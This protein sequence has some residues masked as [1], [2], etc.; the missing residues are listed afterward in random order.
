MDI[1]DDVSITDSG[2]DLAGAININ[3]AQLE[4]LAALPGFDR[5][6]AQAVIS[7]RKSN[8][9]LPNIAHL[10]KVPGMNQTIF[11]QVAPLLS[12]RSETYRI[13][14]EGRI[15]STG[16]RRRIQEI[17]HIGLHQV[18]TLEHREDDL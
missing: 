14:S 4:V 7:Y 11:K 17:V 1:A 13:L 10:L 9:F 16:A 15:T 3:T 2:Q 12:A 6:L 5:D 18:T 8:G